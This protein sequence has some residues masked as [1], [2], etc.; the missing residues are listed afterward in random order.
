MHLFFRINRVNINTL[1]LIETKRCDHLR[2]T[3]YYNNNNNKQ[4]QQIFI[5]NN[6]Y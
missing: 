6:S 2:I 5:Y 4:Q 3:F 1:V